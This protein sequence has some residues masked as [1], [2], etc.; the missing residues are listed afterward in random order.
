M[1]HPRRSGTLSTT[2]VRGSLSLFSA[3]VWLAL[4]PLPARGQTSDTKPPILESFSFNPTTVD[5]SGSS[6]TVV[7]TA[8]ATDD[9][10]GVSFAQV[11][12]R[13]PVSNQQLTATLVR[14]GGN[15]LDAT[16]TGSVTLPQF[17]EAGIW[18]V[19]GVNVV[20][21]ASNFSSITTQVL[22]S[23]GFQTQL[24]V[25][26]NPDSQA[27]TITGVSLSLSSIDVSSA[28]QS[29]SVGLQVTDNLSGVAFQNCVT[30]QLT[31]FAV[32]WRSPSGAQNRWLAQ[33]AFSLVTG[34]DR[35]N[36]LWVSSFVMPKSSEPGAWTIQSLSVHDCAGNFRFLNA[37]QV[38]AAGLQRTLNVTSSPADVQAPILTSLAFVPIAINTSTGSQAVKVRIGI[39]DILSG[40]D[41]SPTTPQ[42]SFF[43]RGIQFRSPSGVQSR[44]AAFFAPFT[45]A[46]GDARNGVWESTL[47]FAQFSEEGTWK[48]DL[49]TI[50]DRTRNI[51]SFTT[52][53]L[54]SLGFSTTL[55]VIKPS[56][57]PDDTIGS[58]GGQVT[59][60]TFGDRATV[61]FPPGAL[62]QPTQVA[63]DVLAKPLDIPNPTGF[64]GP[65]TLFVNIHLTPE[66]NFP[67]A[68]PGLTLVLPLRDPMI[69][70][71]QMKLY[72]VD[73][74]TGQLVPAINFLGREVAGF[75]D[76]DGLSATFQGIS[77]LST[78]VGLIPEALNVGV[79]I[80]PG[81]SPNTIN[82]KS[83]GVLPVAILSTD[84][85]DATT[86]RPETV[87]LA[88]ASV[89]LKGNGQPVF[90]FEDVNGDGRLD[91]VL[92]FETQSLEITSTDT[93]ANLT[94]RTKDGLRIVGHDDIRIVPN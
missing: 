83:K 35:L 13:S 39:S 81:D 69:S 91:I 5:V 63:I 64:T 19:S 40:A 21:V 9:L 33:S 73:P 24:L 89:R 27:P 68:A 82:L 58:D 87:L 75:V 11:F 8:R 1:L 76:A 80:K 92:Q 26:S 79:D 51:A 14:G 18:S 25:I 90:S 78:V 93:Q 59:D 10:S 62:T 48:V 72:R 6:Q 15:P 67:L 3:V 42:L 50:K 16:L 47:T 30:G 7:I 37:T 46:S 88:G 41:F 32:V 36:G 38:A 31:D 57:I 61:F 52:A 77:R 12:F 74:A 20:D 44:S 28:D 60:Q 54:Q 70:G 49:L 34:G 17:A 94:G 43:E 23:R 71:T 66:P 53:G 56:L 4:L 86:V 65:G 55:E 85:F 84:T 45:L 22:A 2:R 29:V